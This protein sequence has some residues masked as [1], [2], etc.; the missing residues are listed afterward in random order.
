MRIYVGFP[1]K[2]SGS[3]GISKKIEFSENVPRL[4]IIGIRHFDG[5]PCVIYITAKGALMVIAG[6]TRYTMFRTLFHI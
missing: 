3:L 2:V 1:L 5:T 6:T 4:V